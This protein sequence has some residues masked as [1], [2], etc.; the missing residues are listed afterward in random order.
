MVRTQL[1]SFAPLEDTTACANDG[2]PQ[3]YCGDQRQPNLKSFKIE[4]NFGRNM[5]LPHFHI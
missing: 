5:M 2:N 1:P 4:Y 3:G